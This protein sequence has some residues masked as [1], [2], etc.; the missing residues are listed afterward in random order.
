MN[1]PKLNDDSLTV[2]LLNI[3]N[4]GNVSYVGFKSISV[5]VLVQLMANFT[6]LYLPVQDAF[7]IT[8]QYTVSRPL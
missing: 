7:T 3:I 6:K 2:Q 4:S 8:A 1:K 5:N